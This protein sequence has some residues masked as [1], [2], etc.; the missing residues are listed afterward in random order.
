MKITG[1]IAEYDPFHSGHAFQLAHARA[2]GAETIVVCMSCD[3][4]QR[5][6]LSSV[7]PSV[8]VRAALQ[9]GADLV[10]ALPAPWSCS[11]AEQFGA[12]G[13]HLLSAL[14]CTTLAFGAETPDTAALMALAQALDSPAFAPLLKEELQGG[15]PFALARARAMER[16][17]PALAPLLNT[18]NNLLGVEYCKAILRSG[19]PMQP[20]ALPRLGA[21][22]HDSAPAAAEAGAATA[23]GSAIRQFWQSGDWEFMA[24]CVPPQAL[25]LYRAAHAEGLTLSPQRMEVA[26]LSRLRAMGEQDFASIRGIGEGLEHRLTAAVRSACTLEELYSALNT[27]RYALSRLRRLVLDAALGY[28]QDTPALPPFLLVLGAR[29]SALPLC[30]QASLPCGTSLAALSRENP[31]CAA[32]AAAHGAAADL[33]ALCRTR[34]RPMGLAY[35]QKPIIL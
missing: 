12:S 11:S 3:T 17:A 14:G 34:P 29:R 28:R 8:R 22:H 20:L 16:F 5:G 21:G 32:A 4:V 2:Q 27:R 30:G 18:P 9:Q 35:T 1:V 31:S 6:G 26:L 24:A 23:S 25:E 13:V 33:S 15:T 7:P 19:S 10:V